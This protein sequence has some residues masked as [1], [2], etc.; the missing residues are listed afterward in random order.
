M[1]S[2]LTII[3]LLK[4]REEYNERFIK[5]FEEN[6]ENYNLII[7]DGSKKK[8][9]S[10]IIK[11]INRNPF[12]K[13][14]KFPEDKTYEL[15]YK[16]IYN[17]IKSVKTK[18][19]IFAANDDFFIYK[20]I[21]KCLDFLKF[22]KNFI[23]AGGTMIG[24]SIIKSVK[25]KTK[26]ELD[27]FYVLYGQTKLDE[28]NN[29]KRFNTFIKNFSDLPTV[30]IIQ[31]DVLLKNYKY[32][33]KL[34]K[35]NIE[36]KSHFAA[37]F[38]VISGRIK[39]FKDPL[40]LHEAHSK[41]QGS[42]RTKMHIKAFNNKNFLKDLRFFDNILSRKLKVQKNFVV[43]RYYSYVLRK[44]LNAFELPSEPSVHQMKLA[45]YKKLKRKFFK[46]NFKKQKYLDKQKLNKDVKIQVKYIENN[47]IN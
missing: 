20:N 40:I 11:K 43:N 35:N 26:F 14:L 7:S 1:K 6:N 21:R 25:I 5:Y 10:D 37:L 46:T 18:Y 38:N 17:S 8:L 36:F 41:N 32:S 27:N 39:I 16:K 13:Y 15:F 9:N 47:L 42:L 12:I 22:N 19:I 29:I 28:K 45:L 4:D 44:L 33:S 31:K 30:S 23:G 24:F 34:F 3:L 2:E